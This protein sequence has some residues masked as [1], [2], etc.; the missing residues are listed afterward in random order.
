MKN[1][2]RKEEKFKSTAYLSFKKKDKIKPNYTIVVS[3]KIVSGAVS[4]NLLKRR[5]REAIK[6]VSTKNSPKGIFYTK[7]GIEKLSFQK[8][9]SEISSLIRK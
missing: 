7:K 4:R 2:F 1:S 6:S 8:I 5:I 3:K 9:K